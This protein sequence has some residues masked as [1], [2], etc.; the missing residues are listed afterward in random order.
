MARWK[1]VV[2][3]LL[4]VLV[5]LVAGAVQAVLGWRALLFGP[6]ARP[7]TTRTF[8][9]TPERLAR[10]RYLAEAHL[11]CVACHS[12][13]DW[14]QPGAPIKPGRAF[15]GVVWS[16]EG[17]PWLTATNLTPDAETGIGRVSDDA[18]DRA[19]REGIGFDGRALF[20]LMPWQEYR[21]LPDEDVA[22]LVVYLRSLPAVGNPLPRT[23]LPFPLSVIVKGVPS[24]LEGPVPVP[25]LSTPARRGEHLLRTASCHHCHTLMR[26]GSFDTTLDMAGGNVFQTPTGP[27]AVTNVTLDATGIAHYDEATFVQVMQTGKLGTLHPFMPWAFYKDMTEEDLRAIW[28]YLKTLRPVKHVVTNGTPPTRCAVC[29]NEHA[30]GDRNRQ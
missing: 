15:A 10:G 22:A 16:G 8:E 18:L 21:R 26:R 29:G 2:L 25:D 12:E 28:V 30:G 11:A 19:I 7:L 1:K 27:V 4:I 14:K 20:P 24:P 23:V 3:G 9:S 17:M 5:L 13:R 6:R